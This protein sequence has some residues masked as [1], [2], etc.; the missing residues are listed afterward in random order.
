MPDALDALFKPRSV[1][2]I[3]ASAR[4]HSVGHSVVA[5]LQAFGYAGAQYPV[6]PTATEIRGLKAYPNLEAIP[7]PVDLAHIIIP[8]SQVPQAMAECGRKGV[9][10]VIINSGGFKEIGAEGERLQEAFLAEARRYG[11]RVLGPNCQGIINT[12]PAHRAYCNFTNTLPQAGSISLAA[13]SGGVGGFMLQSLADIGVG[14]RM[15]ASNGN[16]CDISIAEILRYWGDDAGTRAI[17]VYT[18]GFADPK[19]FYDVACDVAA[20]KPVLAMKAGRTEQGAKA[21]SS[22]TGSLAGIDIATEL[23]FEKA[24]ILS[25]SDEGEL[26]RAALAF[27]TQPMPRGPRVAILTNTG[28]PAVIATDVLVAAGLEVPPFGANS[29]ARLRAALLPQAALENPVD[30]IAT[31]GPEHFRAALEVML[32]DDAI[33]ALYVNFVTPSFTDTQA[34]AREIVAAN[35]RRSK[36]MV[37]NFMSDLSQERFRVTQ[38]ILLEGGVPCYG[39]PGEAACALGALHRYG[40]LRARPHAAPRVFEDVD[41]ARGRTLIAGAQRAGR[42]VL[43]ADEVATLFECYRIPLAAWAMADDADAAVAA[44]GQIGLPVVVKVD[45]PEASHKSDVGGVTVNLRDA[46]AVRAAVQDMQQ[47]LAHLGPLRFMVQKFMPAGQELIAGATKSGALGHLL[48]FGLGGIHVEV[49]KDVVFKLGPLSA[50]E[51]EAM[52]DAIRA[53]ALLHGVRGQAGV[54]RPA[55]VELLQRVSMLLSDLPMIEELDLNPVLG[56]AD[57]VCAVDGRVRISATPEDTR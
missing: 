30:V 43:A 13:L 18:E 50:P 28:G 33:D 23:I 3:G 25:F 29:V 39:Y 55:L 40:V 11:I 45:S 12:D 32:D 48:M 53:K 47:R 7:G 4:E 8:S 16:A 6:H 56:Y 9:R 51:A 24:G 5:N 36:P 26:I 19:A 27:S 1:A 52:L 34:I 41:A 35:S 38:R 20:R 44:A 57:S 54:C 15:Y 17:L 21:A 22:H 37:C 2:I 31:A 42:T 14:V 46:A 49:L 10:A